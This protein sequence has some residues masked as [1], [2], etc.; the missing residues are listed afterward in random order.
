MLNSY[1]ANNIFFRNSKKNCLLLE[2]TE[3][4]NGANQIRV[5]FQNYSEQFPVYILKGTQ[6]TEPP[7]IFG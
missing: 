1:S 2:Q 7:A 5:N 6:S 4:L 3:L